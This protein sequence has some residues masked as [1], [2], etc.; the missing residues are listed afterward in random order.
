MFQIN[1]HAKPSVYEQLLQQFRFALVSGKFRVHD[2]L[3]S[4]RV[5]GEQLAISFHTVR[6]VYQV[7][8]EE[9]WVSSSHG[10]GF[11]VIER[12]QP[13]KAT[14]MEEGASLMQDTIQKLVSMG[15]DEEEIRVL[16]EEQ[17]EE[18]SSHAPSRALYLTAAFKE[19]AESCAQQLMLLLHETITPVPLGEIHRYRQA[20]VVI[21]PLANVRNIQEKLPNAMVLG[22]QILYPPDILQEIA[23]LLTAQTLAL[24]TQQADAIAPLMQHLKQETGFSGQLFATDLE[25]ITPQIQAYIQTAD[26]VVYTPQCRRR[27]Q[28]QLMKQKNAVLAPFVS[29]ASCDFV[30]HQLH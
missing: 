2:T 26:L 13:D 18:W 28:G 9:G 11:K 4:T 12:A 1:R 22:I 21:C 30:L 5:L 7:L 23:Q 24:V 29:R 15:L 19:A 14:R 6:K 16:L 27:L 25:G 17:L 8:E 3:P 20:E 10:R